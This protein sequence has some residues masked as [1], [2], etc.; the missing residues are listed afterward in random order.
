MK[1]ARLNQLDIKL[2]ADIQ[3]GHHI[4]YKMNVSKYQIKHQILTTHWKI[5]NFKKY[6]CNTNSSLPV[7]YEEASKVSVESTSTGIH[8]KQIF[9]H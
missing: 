5:G 7:L 8:H 1:I 2:P 3:V 6:Q 4:N 9:N